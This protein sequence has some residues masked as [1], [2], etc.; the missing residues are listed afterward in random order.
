MLPNYR[1]VSDVLQDVNLKLWERQSDFEIGTNFGAWACTVARYNILNL[2]AKLK[3]QHWLLFNDSLVEKLAEPCAKN[4]DPSHLD[5]M[6]AAL[7][8]C[9]SRLKPK[10]RELL[11]VRYFRDDSVAEHARKT[12]SSAQV[13]SVTLHRIRM[14][15]RECVNRQLVT[16]GDS[17]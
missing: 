15:L 7:H 17:A 12:G 1:D 6:R 14:K 4:Y 5:G 16:G 9:L 10:E 3:R 8:R 13:I 2:R 11:R